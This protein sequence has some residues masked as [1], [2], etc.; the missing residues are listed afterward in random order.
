MGYCQS[1][2][3][4][5]VWLQPRSDS[6]IFFAGRIQKMCSQLAALASVYFN[7]HKNEVFVDP[8]FHGATHPPHILGSMPTFDCRVWSLPNKTEATNA[9]L[10]R[11]QDATKN[12]VSMVAQH[13]YSH[14]ELQNKTCGDMHELLFQK[15]INWNDYP[16]FFK[17]G[18][19]VQRK[20]TRRKFSA[21]ELDKLPLKHAARTNP[22]LIVQR[23]DVVVVSMPP[24]ARVMNRENVIFGSEDPQVLSSPADKVVGT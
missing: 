3:I 7:R 11:E 2:E 12:S 5:L 20:P 6:E 21:A 15:G 22:D 19:Y 8:T 14:K 18:T 17:R 24:L 16:D 10:W 13:Y 9:F 4:T 23:F 1:D